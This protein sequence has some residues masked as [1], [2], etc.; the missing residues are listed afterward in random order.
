MNKILYPYEFHGGQIVY[1]CPVCHY[2]FDDTN[3]VKRMTHKCLSQ[4]TIYPLQ[5]DKVT[6]TNGEAH[7]PE[8][9]PKVKCQ[10]CGKEYSKKGIKKHEAS[11]KKKGNIKEITE[12]FIEEPIA[13]EVPLPE[14][15][16]PKKKKIKVSDIPK[17]EKAFLVPPKAEKSKEVMEAPQPL[18][19]KKSILKMIDS[20]VET[21]KE[22]IKE[23]K[24]KEMKGLV[25]K[26]IND[27]V[28]KPKEHEPE[29]E[30]S[31]V[32]KDK[33][34]FAEKIDKKHYKCK[35]C[36]KYNGIRSGFYKHF[37]KHHS[38]FF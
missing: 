38:D 32:I 3:P 5:G 30:P 28:L 31:K 34:E 6:I 8:Q 23:E 25:L 22:A 14:D 13:H 26:M 24:R 36:G 2:E 15:E 17:P 20:I 35:I 4:T 11:C 7:Y 18:P 12:E 37:D 1:T 19:S 10:Y 16:T 27:L 29:P 21:P 33:I 9:P